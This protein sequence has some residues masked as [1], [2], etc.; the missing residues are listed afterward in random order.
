MNTGLKLVDTRRRGTIVASQ[1][2]INLL[3]GMS[4]VVVQFSLSSSRDEIAR[5]LEPRSNPPSEILRCMET[6]VQSRIPITCRWQPFVPGSSESAVEFAARV[7][8]TGCSHVSLEHLKVPV[9]R[10]ASLWREFVRLVGLDLYEEY[11]GQHATRDG[12]ELVLPAERKL[13]AVIQTALEVRRCGMTFGA[14]D[15]EFQYLSDTSCC[16][17][18]VDQFPGFQNYFKHQ[19][20]YAVRKCK[21]RMI[22]YESIQ[23]EWVPTGSVDRYLNSRSRIGVRN[24]GKA[25]IADHIK[26][27]WNQV[28]VPGSPSSFFGVRSS[29]SRRS[30]M[31]AYDWDPDL[32]IGIA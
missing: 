29:N 19:I 22:T 1:P 6:L 7:S 14:A 31:L 23:N 32:N 4:S 28:E 5:V 3:K 10:N 26:I 16:C 8:S 27:R 30:G 17:S 25:S 11:K 2:Y 20:G 13:K 24:R 21:G 12:R 9:E 15:N 18:G